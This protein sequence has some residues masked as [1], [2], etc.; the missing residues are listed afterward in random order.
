MKPRSF[1]VL[2]ALMV[3]WSYQA[4][5]Q[6]HVVDSLQRIVSLDNRD[7]LHI[8]AL[9]Y[10]A[11]E[12]TRTDMPRAK[13]YLFKAIRLANELGTT[14]GVSGSYSQLITMNQNLGLKDSAN[15]YF[16]KLEKLAEAHPDKW[17]VQSN[18]LHTAGLYYKN[19]GNYRLA[20]SFQLKGYDLMKEIEPDAAG[21]AGLLLNIGNTYY[22]MGEIRSAADYHI[23]ALKKFEEIG[24]LRG[25]S[26]CLQSLGNDFMELKVYATAEQYYQRSL[27]LKEGLND[28][29]GVGTAW[30]GLASVARAQ[31]NF[32]KALRY[33]NLA[34]GRARELRMNGE[35]GKILFEIARIEAEK[36]NIPKAVDYLNLSHEK[37]KATPDSSLLAMVSAELTQLQRA[38]NNFHLTE[39]TF[40]SK[41][42]MAGRS[43]NKPGLVDGY[44]DLANLYAAN[45]QFEQAY[46][47][48]NQYIQLNDS[49]RGSEIVGQLKS[50][51]QAY[52]RE[53]N[54]KEIAL[55][56]KDQELKEAT[57]AKQKSDQYL[58]AIAFV[59]VVFI[60][61]ILFNRYKTI[62]KV[63]RQVE[64]EKVRNHIARDLHDDIGSTLSSINLISKLALED[65]NDVQ[66]HLI[67][68][69]DNSS[70]MMESMSDIVWSINP[71]HDSFGQVVMKMKEFAGEILEPK[72]IA[73]TIS[74]EEEVC[75]IPVDIE[76]RKNL[77]LIFKEAINNAAKYSG[78]TDVQVTFRRDQDEV[79]FTISDNGSGFDPSQVKLG[80]G[81]KN[82]EAR[83]KSFNGT[84]SLN[85][86][87]QS[88][89]TSIAV[90]FAIT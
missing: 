53:K 71:S 68:I 15:Y 11:A 65:K 7:T 70:R 57:I 59:S 63:Q 44:K 20:L 64:I 1:A 17:K 33:Y 2:L 82:M 12:Y 85:R 27:K 16:R 22:K 6:K 5:S 81:L 51:E 18:Y 55:L 21:T 56:K 43:G 25:Q 90:K 80:N 10:L 9:V 67:R 66:K 46:N 58:I 83:A 62:N 54:E 40:H 39:R 50:I 34:L 19:E 3:V 36:G 32:A 23:S 35:E 8:S 52:Q 14:H 41:L 28:S 74:G 45:Q 24:N 89:G 78:A 47:F 38:R 73:Y 13:T 79:F 87:H 77:F 88:K 30:V 86:E 29:R 84:L 75:N 42:E 61:L 4:R 31:K 69:A 48:L 60:S 49:I 26:F 76:K 72:N 37:I